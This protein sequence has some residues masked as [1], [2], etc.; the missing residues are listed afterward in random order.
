MLK[1]QSYR[2]FF[3]LIE[4]NNSGR[5]HMSPDIQNEEE[6]KRQ[7]TE[8]HL[9]EMP[10]EALISLLMEISLNDLWRQHID[11]FYAFY[12]KELR[13]QKLAEWAYQQVASGVLDIID[14]CY[15]ITDKGRQIC[16]SIEIDGVTALR[17][18]GVTAAHFNGLGVGDAEEAWLN[19]EH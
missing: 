15:R 12:L 11:G 1:K 3:A 7:Q 14:G 2:V 13:Y 17:F 19:S 18:D 16:K 10:K 4:K 9:S 8:K 5:K 6:M